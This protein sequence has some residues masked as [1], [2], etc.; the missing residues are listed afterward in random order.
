[1]KEDV[2]PVKIVDGVNVT[3]KVILNDYVR[4]ECDVLHE[5]NLDNLLDFV[6]TIKIATI[7]HNIKYAM[8]KTT[9]IY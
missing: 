2:I 9:T 5:N 3:N 4:G 7:V 1:M 6:T 8:N